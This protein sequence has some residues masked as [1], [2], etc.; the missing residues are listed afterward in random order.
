MSPSN[1]SSLLK[2]NQTEINNEGNYSN[3]LQEAVDE[4]Q[5]EQKLY[6]NNDEKEEKDAY[7][8]PVFFAGV[9]ILIGCWAV[10]NLQYSNA[11]R[12]KKQNA[13]RRK[14]IHKQYKELKAKMGMQKE[15]RRNSTRNSTTDADG[16]LIIED[17]IDAVS[18][19][20]IDSQEFLNMVYDADKLKN[21]SDKILKR[22]DPNAAKLGAV[23]RRSGIYNSSH[24]STHNKSDSNDCRSNKNSIDIDHIQEN[25]QNEVFSTDPLKN[26]AEIQSPDIYVNKINE[27]V[28]QTTKNETTT[29]PCQISKS[30]RTASDT[31]LPSSDNDKSKRRSTQNHNKQNLRN[32]LSNDPNNHH[33]RTNRKN[34]NQPISENEDQKRR[35]NY[36]KAE[37]TKSFNYVELASSIARSS[38]TN[39]KK[40]DYEQAI[41]DFKRKYDVVE[42][43]KSVMYRN[44]RLSRRNNR[45]SISVEG[46]PRK[47]SELGLGL[48]EDVPKGKKFAR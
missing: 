9:V 33:N 38:R 21:L 35:E 48:T 24:L 43:R 36:R 47:T 27:F 6:N 37:R 4:F 26:N 34:Q 15:K 31:S 25:H 19:S 29:E 5:N 23:G 18:H 1:N 17:G 44:S 2:I 14:N 10:L 28:P 45:H 16:N 41:S 39:A 46:D 13:Q 30:K 32:T 40:Y 7:S 22:K 42:E 8:L 20:S 12:T 11:R 3:Y